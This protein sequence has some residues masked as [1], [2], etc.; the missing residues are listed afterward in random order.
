M[1][2]QA[3]NDLDLKIQSFVMH[4]L[5]SEN[6]EF[7]LKSTILVHFCHVDTTDSCAD[8]SINFRLA[9]TFKRPYL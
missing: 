4:R 5:A 8:D 7:P 1:C 3:V 6:F 2:I 9:K